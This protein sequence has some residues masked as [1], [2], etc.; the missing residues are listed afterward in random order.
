FH[1]Y[2]WSTPGV[3]E[4]LSTL[5]RAG[6][7]LI[8]SESDASLEDLAGILTRHPR[9][10]VISLRTAYTLSRT[11]FALLAQFPT[12]H[13]EFSRFAVHNVVAEVTKRFGPERLVFGTGMP[14]W[15]P[16]AAMALVTYAQI[17]PAQRAIVAGDGLRALLRLPAAVEVK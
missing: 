2:S 15:D 13:V 9:L 4:T 5:E 12:Y 10:H 17:T 7:P 3:E 11:V 1:G 14:E 16:G 6:Y 8:E